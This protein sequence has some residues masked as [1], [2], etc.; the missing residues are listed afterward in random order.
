MEHLKSQIQRHGFESKV[1][2]QH[3][4]I[5]GANFRKHKHTHTDERTN[6]TGWTDRRGS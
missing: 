5:H 2:Y 3:M 4:H 1:S 6:R